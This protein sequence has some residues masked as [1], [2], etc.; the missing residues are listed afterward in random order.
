MFILEDIK[1]TDKS[2]SHRKTFPLFCNMV[3]IISKLTVAR[4]GSRLLIASLIEHYCSNPQEE[5]GN[6]FLYF[7]YAK[8]KC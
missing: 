4:Y 6:A 5:I 1:N 8:D 7:V 3:H 2:V